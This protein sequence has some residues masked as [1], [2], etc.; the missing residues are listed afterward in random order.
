M[1]KFI[2][3]DHSELKKIYS[4][5]LY[6]LR[7]E[8][9]HDRLGWDVS[10]IQDMEFDKYDKTGTKYILGIYKNKI[11]C[12]VRFIK[13][14][15]PNMITHTFH[16]HFKDVELPK[17]QIES[18][19]FFVDKNNASQLLGKSY[20]V[21]NML[22]LATINYARQFGFSGIYTIVSRAM[23]T[24]LRRSGWQMTPLREAQ[25]SENESIYLVF[26]PAEKAD[27]LQMA[28]KMHTKLGSPM[29]TL[30]NWPISLTVSEQV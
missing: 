3:V 11:I 21:S 25:L 18:S 19:R 13:T 8:I 15:Q 24:I 6:R 29:S 30:L 5:D 7:K 26:L 23:L 20:P 14:E 4:K 16:K 22:F 28:Q 12:S 9:F 17:N 27:Q 10:Y 2:D 1:F